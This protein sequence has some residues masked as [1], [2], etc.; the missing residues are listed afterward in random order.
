MNKRTDEFLNKLAP[1]RAK[2]CSTQPKAQD[3][4]YDLGTKVNLNFGPSG[5]IGPCT[6]TDR[7]LFEEL[8]GRRFEGYYAVFDIDDNGREFGMGFLPA[9]FFTPID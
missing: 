1:N 5:Q 4:Q 6:I 9:G 7:L 8:D 3:F 2:V